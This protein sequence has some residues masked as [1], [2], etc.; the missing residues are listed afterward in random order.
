MRKSIVFLLAASLFLLTS[1]SSGGP[2]PVIA[3]GVEIW[4]LYVKVSVDS[5][6][7]VTI[8]GGLAARIP[9]T[10]TKTP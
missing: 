5:L 1:C 6:G 3:G 7:Q 8:S 4:P 9:T 2:A 10:P